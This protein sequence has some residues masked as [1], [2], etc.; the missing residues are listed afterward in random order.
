MVRR[1]DGFTLIEVLVALAVFGVLSVMA[2]MALGAVA[3]R[4]RYE[5][6]A[7]ARPGY[8]ARRRCGTLRDVQCH[9]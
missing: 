6:R 1:S 4:T 5:N 9:L 8:D 7:G 3:C 2:Y